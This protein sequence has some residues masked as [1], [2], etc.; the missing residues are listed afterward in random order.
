MNFT[1]TILCLF[2]RRKLLKFLTLVK[3]KKE[4]QTL[5]IKDRDI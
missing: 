3:K 4:T 1:M 2:P 5:L